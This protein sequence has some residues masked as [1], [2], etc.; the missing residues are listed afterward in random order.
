MLDAGGGGGISFMASTAGA[1]G[2]WDS[3]TKFSVDPDQAQ[4]LITGLEEAIRELQKLDRVAEQLTGANTP[5]KDPYSG[6]ATV[7]MRTTAG[8]SEGGYSWANQ[9]A[10]EALEKTIEN[11]N[12][13]LNNYR[14]KDASASAGLKSIQG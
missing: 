11:I 3:Q 8:T 9:K 4:K 10:V 6:F 12:T 14:G 2:N 5:G 7:A 1:S 13:A